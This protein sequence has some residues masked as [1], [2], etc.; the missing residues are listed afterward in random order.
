LA[1]GLETVIVDGF[2]IEDR[3]MKA[4][5]IPAAFKDSSRHVQAHV[6]F[7]ASSAA[8]VGW[9]LPLMERDRWY[10]S[11][12]NVT[13][14]RS[15]TLT[16]T[17]FQQPW[18]KQWVKTWVQT[19][20]AGNWTFNTSVSHTSRLLY[21]SRVLAERHPTIGGPQDLTRQ[22]LLDYVAWIKLRADAAPSQRQGLVS[23]LKVLIEDH[24]LNDWQPAIP[25][26][27]MLRQG[28]LPRREEMLP[29]PIEEHLLRQVL[30]P[31]SLAQA[32]PDLR[33]QLIILDGHGL[34][35]GSLVELTIDCLGEDADGFPTL[36]YRNTKRQ[37]ER[38]HPIR[39]PEVVKAIQEQQ[40]R[41][42]TRHPETLWLFPAHSAN[43]HGKRHISTSAVRLA[44]I[45]YQD[46]I[47]LTDRGGHPAK[48]TLH[49]FRHTFG[50]RELNNGAPQEVV[51]ELLDHDDP[52][53]TRGYARLTGERL[54]EH[55][56][57]AAR[58]N[59]SGERLETL[60]PDSPLADLAWMK[61][62]LN[63]ARV[64]LPNGYCALPLQQTCEVQNAC[65]DCTDYFVTTPEFIPAHEA[66]RERTLELID[67]ADSSGQTRIAEKNRL[68][69]V[70]L[71]TLL[72][73]LRSA[74]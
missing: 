54:R 45:E 32:R 27:A 20:L 53:M 34:R 9:P 65:L 15:K 70:K 13:T 18:L 5:P 38:L 10:A 36:R 21:F 14:S 41:A 46:R 42:R 44:F 8:E 25:E 22:V 60:L 7:A 56:V 43:A 47:E 55:F 64:T 62:R 33:T 73:S 74:P 51:Q 17:G 23:S 11:D 57:A 50:T 72:A 28:E 39:D 19:R 1:A 16:W 63:R 12:F 40:R 24:R 67:A 29:R 58:F 69:L 4:V 48:I 31:Q 3:W 6:R 2:V 59:S 61:E 66:Q 30:S 68:V 37:R 26:S 71:D 49:Q 35:I 52:G